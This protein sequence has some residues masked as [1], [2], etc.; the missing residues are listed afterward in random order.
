MVDLTQSMELS[1]GIERKTRWQVEQ[2]LWD[3]IVKSQDEIGKEL[4]FVIYGYDE[5]LRKIEVNAENKTVVEPVGATT[6]V[7]KTLSELIAAQVD[8][9]LSAVIWMGDATQTVLPASVDPQQ[10]ARQLTQLDIPI[11]L[12]GI[13]PRGDGDRI[14]DLALEGVPEQVNVFS[15][16]NTQILGMLHATSVMNRSVPVRLFLKGTGKPPR[17]LAEQVLRPTQ[18]DQTIPF[19]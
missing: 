10:T 7:G 15:S 12:F 9:P 5:K 3:K 4:P 19:R 17:L 2:D 14:K 16:A 13:G 6:D 11:F 8:P 18:P 1:S